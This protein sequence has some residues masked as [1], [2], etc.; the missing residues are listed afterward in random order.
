[1]TI[2]DSHVHLDDSRFDADRDATIERALAA[3]VDC[4]MAI[5]TGNG[6]PDLETAIRFGATLVRIGS[7]LFGPRA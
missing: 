4:M 6:P 7:A 3:G 2:V 1:M 5:G